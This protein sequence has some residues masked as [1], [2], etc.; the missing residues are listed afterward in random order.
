MIKIQLKTIISVLIFVS[1][2]LSNFSTSSQSVAIYNLKFELNVKNVKYSQY[3][4]Y[5]TDGNSTVIIALDSSLF[6][7]GKYF[8]NETMVYLLFK[9]WFYPFEKLFGVSFNIKNITTYV[10]GDN[11]LDKSMGV[12]TQELNWKNASGIDDPNVNGNTYDWLLIYQ[13]NYN[14]GRNRA[15][16][17]FG[18][19]LIISHNQPGGWTSNQ[20]ILIHEIA[21]IF[22]ALHDEHGVV[23]KEWYGDA[24][25]SIMNYTD[26]TTLHN[27]GFDP[28]NLPIDEHNFDII[29][30]S[31]YRFDHVDADADNLPNWYE[32]RYG[33]DSSF[34]DSFMDFDDDGLSNL[35]EY[36]IGTNPLR[37][38]SDKDGYSDWAENYIGTSPLNSSEVPQVDDPLIFPWTK[39]QEF[40]TNEYITLQ[41]RTI[42]SN[43]GI[44]KIYQNSSEKVSDNWINESIIFIVEDTS[45]GLWNFTCLVLEPDGDKASSTILI[46]FVE[47]R[48]NPI[49]IIAAMLGLLIIIIFTKRK[50]I[51]SIR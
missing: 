44:Y 43:R 31:R 33:F 13:A 21:H 9:T 20:L 50:S 36:L 34:N 17:I 47:S 30:S 45:S 25:Y 15:N 23:E 22:G 11:S 46:K 40:Y 10:A 8:F 2:V 3:N 38:D 41:W 27:E 49:P 6:G 4:Q 12:V 1:A 37:H 26:L 42:S 39:K 28:D 18:N 48:G 7:E 16:A 29:N 35:D 14:G 51:S 24:E 19:A 5:N 32:F